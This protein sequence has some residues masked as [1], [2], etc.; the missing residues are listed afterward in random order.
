M[1]ELTW[2]RTA[3]GLSLPGLSDEPGVM[4]GGSLIPAELVPVLR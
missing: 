3:R 4:A 1:S 2:F